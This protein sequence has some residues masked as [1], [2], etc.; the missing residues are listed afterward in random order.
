M[1]VGGQDKF[2]KKMMAK[3]NYNGQG[4]SEQDLW[5]GNWASR[6]AGEA[7]GHSSCGMML[8]KK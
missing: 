6:L 4:R 3:L 5:L 1:D 2:S 7:V 8:L